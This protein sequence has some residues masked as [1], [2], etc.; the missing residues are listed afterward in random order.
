MIPAKSWQR[1]AM[2]E[3]GFPEFSPQAVA[4]LQKIVSENTT[5]IL[6]TS[7]RSRFTLDEW[8]RIFSRRGI[9][10]KKLSRLRLYK[11]RL[12]RREEL[13]RRFKTDKPTDDFVII[14]DDKSLNELPADLKKNL[15]QTQPFIGLTEH[16]LEQIQH[17]LSL[18]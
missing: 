14:D 5:V 18:A 9:Q 16:Q 17:V 10:V 4:V 11:N 15:I 1:P 2:L 3:D 12:S 13:L 6:T 8:K 7:H